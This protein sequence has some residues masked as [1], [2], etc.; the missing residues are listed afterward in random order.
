MKRNGP[1]KGQ[2]VE[3]GRN[4]GKT[5][6]TDEARQ[7]DLNLAWDS[8]AAPAHPGCRLRGLSQQADAFSHL[9]GGPPH[10]AV[11][12]CDCYR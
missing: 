4:Q 1:K 6:G 2:P 3:K 8:A 10:S 5:A 9:I 12:A 11:F 7:A